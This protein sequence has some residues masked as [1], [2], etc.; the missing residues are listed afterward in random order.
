MKVDNFLVGAIIY[1]AIF[2]ILVITVFVILPLMEKS[3]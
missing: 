2:F 3:L 1:P